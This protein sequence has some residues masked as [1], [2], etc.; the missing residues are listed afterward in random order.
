MKSL[1]AVAAVQH[2]SLAIL[3]LILAACSSMPDRIPWVYYADVQQ[4][5]IVGQYMIDRLQPG[6]EKNKVRIIMGTP[7]LTDT[8]NPNRWEYVHTT[9][10]GDGSEPEY[11]RVTIIFKNDR[12]ARIEGDMQP[13]NNQNELEEHPVQVIIVPPK[14]KKKGWFNRNQTP[15]APVYLQSR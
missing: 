14:P 7:L 11:G 13:H 10:P 8:F 6:M 9:T 3:A 12:L 2:S 5:N 1:I 4:G 15:S